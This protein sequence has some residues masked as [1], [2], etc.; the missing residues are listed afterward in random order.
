MK[1][2][3]LYNNLLNQLQGQNLNYNWTDDKSYLSINLKQ[4]YLSI[5]ITLNQGNVT[6]VDMLISHKHNNPSVIQNATV[7][8]GLDYF[9]KQVS[10]SLNNPTDLPAQATKDQAANY[11]ILNDNYLCIPLGCKNLASNLKNNQVATQKITNM[12]QANAQNI[13]NKIN[14]LGQQCAIAK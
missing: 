7:Y 8:S 9:N 11:L 4:D 13:K 12:I 2:S 3:N 10:K 5:V 6:D 1:K 14:R